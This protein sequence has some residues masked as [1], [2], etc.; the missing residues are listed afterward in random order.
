[1]MRTLHELTRVETGFKADHLLTTRF[2]LAGDQWTRDKR[3]AFFDDLQS[4][5]RALPGVTNAAFAF[6]LPIDGSNWNSIFIVGDKPVPAARAAAERRVHAGQRRL[7]RDDGDAAG[8]RAVL[9]QRPTRA[10]SPKVT[11]VNESL[12]KRLWPGEDA[13]GKRLK[14]GWPENPSAVARGGRGGRAT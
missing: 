13:I 9:R 4:R 6:S 8:A 5:L 14:Q 11:V 2:V 3:V 12:A 7:L 10:T 1:M